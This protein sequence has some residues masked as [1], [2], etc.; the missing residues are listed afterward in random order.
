MLS[1]STIG[2]T[3]KKQTSAFLE[4]PRKQK[5]KLSLVTQPLSQYTHNVVRQQPM[6]VSVQAIITQ[7]SQPT[8]SHTLSD[9]ARLI[10]SDTTPSDFKFKHSN[11]LAQENI[12]KQTLLEFQK[13]LFDQ[14]QQ[15]GKIHIVG[16]S[17]LTTLT[18]LSKLS[19][20]KEG[21]PSCPIK[22]DFF[23]C[24]PVAFMLNDLLLKL[25][26]QADTFRE[27]VES[28][29]KAFTF[30]KKEYD[31]LEEAIE[32]HHE[33]TSHCDSFLLKW[34]YHTFIGTMKSSDTINELMS[35]QSIKELLLCD[36]FDYDLYQKNIFD[37]P[38]IQ[39]GT[40]YYLSNI[41]TEDI[42]PKLMENPSN[43]LW[44][45]LSGCIAT[46]RTVSSKSNMPSQLENN[47]KAIQFFQRCN[48]LILST[49]TEEPSLT[50][51]DISLSLR[52]LFQLMHTISLNTVHG[53]SDEKSENTCIDFRVEQN[54]AFLDFQ[55][56]LS[57]TSAEFVGRLNLL[58][59]AYG[60]SCLDEI[61]LSTLRLLHFFVGKSKSDSIFLTP[62][63]K[64]SPSIAFCHIMLFGNMDAQFNSTES[65]TLYQHIITSDPEAEFRASRSLISLLNNYSKFIAS[66]E[67]GS[68]SSFE[69]SYRLPQELLALFST[70]R[71]QSY[72][73]SDFFAMFYQWNIHFK[74]ALEQMN[75]TS[76]SNFFYINA[77]LND[78]TINPHQ[79]N[80]HVLTAYE[81][82]LSDLALFFIKNGSKL[83]YET[84]DGKTA[85]HYAKD[86]SLGEHKRELIQNG[87]DLQL[88]L[89]KMKNNL[90]T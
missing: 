45:H 55:E 16:V 64:I 84:R 62:Q 61:P 68:A 12:P 26:P 70:E 66:F 19:Q 86:L 9:Y 1:T 39:D 78:S 22:V 51:Q 2:H 21:R 79:R 30:D 83:N 15:Y 73:P 18:L 44:S 24:R 10:E 71:A 89:A 80:G 52:F 40:L 34:F 37:H 46:V 58:S 90:V 54:E 57:K 63:K 87:F 38:L 56:S 14:Y 69:E 27:L 33:Q 49:K 53:Y 20:L 3:T 17:P 7:L 72:D 81:N 47:Q 6:N 60:D 35:F 48:Q 50:D 74:K 85:M 36:Q 88:Y 41:P 4:G 23:E 8:S 11:Y 42:P 29:E 65:E 43:I 76:D 82:G 28:F 75:L 25:I 59:N 13:A 77:F 32:K 31:V 67:D 5:A